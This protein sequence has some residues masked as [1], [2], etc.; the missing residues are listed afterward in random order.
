[1]KTLLAVLFVFAA[2]C[3]ADVQAQTGSIDYTFPGSEFSP[4]PDKD[5]SDWAEIFF[6]S[7]AHVDAPANSTWY[8]FQL[9][10]VITKEGANPYSV[11]YAT[12]YVMLHNSEHA[13][14]NAS[15]YFFTAPC[16]IGLY[17]ATSTLEWKVL[18]YS[19]WHTL[20]SETLYFNIVP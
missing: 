14:L 10:T 8:M 3:A 16:E 20:G 15:D 9:T 17:S 1:M 5:K 4:Y 12:A 11:D 13:P 19:T 18:G 6:G 2:L 7:A